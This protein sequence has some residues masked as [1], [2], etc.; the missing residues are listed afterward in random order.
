MFYG[1]TIFFMD[2][3][4]YLCLYMWC[5]IVLTAC[6]FYSM[7]LIGG[8][9]TLSLLI[10]AFFFLTLELIWGVGVHEW[11]SSNGFPCSCIDTDNKEDR[12]IHSSGRLYRRDQSPNGILFKGNSWLNIHIRDSKPVIYFM[13]LNNCE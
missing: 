10:V 1:K 9:C 5:I 6:L 2:I 13:E 12:K 4:I 11:A 7:F 8:S 3:H